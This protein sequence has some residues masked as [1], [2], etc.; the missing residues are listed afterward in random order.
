MGIII[1]AHGTMAPA[2]LELVSM[3]LGEQERVR[4]ID[5]QPGDSLDV[6]GER[7]QAAI[8]DLGREEGIMILTDLKGGSPCN[9]ASLY[10]KTTEGIQVL[11]GFN[12]PMLLEILELREHR[13]D[14]KELAEAALHAG[15]QGMD[16]ITTD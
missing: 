13:G 12:I 9:V 4:C 3:F 14:L 8:Q 15:A 10:Q 11:H 1:A 2:A 6:L 7:F 16:K 5:F